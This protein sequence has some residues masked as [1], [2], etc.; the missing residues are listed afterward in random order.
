MDRVAS[1]LAS[2]N[3]EDSRLVSVIDD[4][5]AELENTSMA[6][7]VKLPCKLVGVHPANRGG[8][9]VSPGD[10]HRLGSVIAAMGFS[11]AACSHAVCVEDADGDAAQFTQKLINSSDGMLGGSAS[12]IKYGSLS[13]SHTNQFLQAAIDGVKCEYDNI[14]MNGCMSV[15]R[16]S[17][18]PAMREALDNGITWLVVSSKAVKSYP[19]LPE[20]VQA[21]KNATGAVHHRE[22]AFQLLQKVQSMAAAMSSRSGSVDWQDISR[23]AVRMSHCTTE[24]L[25]PILAF[26]QKFG[27]GTSTHF[28]EEMGQFYR[29]F[30]KPGRVVPATT[31]QAIADVRLQA[32]ELCPRFMYAV[33]KAQATCPASKTDGG[34]ICKYIS[35]SEIATLGTTRKD[36][37]IE[38]EAVLNECRAVARAQNISHDKVTKALGR[39]DIFVARLVLGKK[40]DLKNMQ[41]VV[42]VAKQFAEELGC[43][44]PAALAKPKPSVGGPSVVQYDDDGKPIAAAAL[45]LHAEGYVVDTMV[46]ATESG[47]IFRIDVIDDDGTVHVTSLSTSDKQAVTYDHFVEKFRKTTETFETFDDW[48]DYTPNKQDTYK[49][50]VTRALALVAVANLATTVDAPRLRIIVKP[51]RSV[52]ADQAYPVH[53]LILVPESNRITFDDRQASA[54][55]VVVGDKAVWLAPAQCTAAFAVPAWILQ[56]T[57]VEDKANMHIQT[58]KV[59]ITVGGNDVDV[60]IQVISNKC[61]LKKG[62]ELF[63]YK[64]AVKQSTV[65]KRHLSLEPVS[66]AKAKAKAGK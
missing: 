49:D 65:A 37:M 36:A 51:T 58:K 50:S 57:T 2:V 17:A 6:W 8:W 11:P 10:V 47:D 24:E 12:D 16:L 61:K 23:T 4:V 54:L 39:L 22:D 31:W 62:D 33:L 48:S 1:L 45:A 5:L 9:G 44:V 3:K 28:V 30:V 38:A 7:R 20:L 60:Q 32:T 66:R 34:K 52:I 56:T 42:D 13:C 18:D 25:A 27:G 21:A 26:A 15:A 29:Q 46:K 41:N 14:S 40:D 53:K 55:K 59:S 43:G 19:S 64:E 63:I 35:A